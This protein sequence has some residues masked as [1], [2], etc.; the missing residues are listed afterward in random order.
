MVTAFGSVVASAL[1]ADWW[2]NHRAGRLKFAGGR[3]SE[4][5][6]GGGDFERPPRG[7]QEGFS[8]PSGRHMAL[9]FFI[10]LLDALKCALSILP[11][12]FERVRRSDS[13]KRRHGVDCHRSHL[14][15]GACGGRAD[16]RGGVRYGCDQR[17]DSRFCQLPQAPQKQHLIRTTCPMNRACL[18]L[19]AG[20]CF[21]QLSDLSRATKPA[22]QRRVNLPYQS[23]PELALR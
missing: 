23:R 5:G 3:G 22:S 7:S 13:L 18:H 12:T 11:S 16:I 2:C 8:A 14:S 1:G 21:P 10:L 20:Q 15:Q 17:F 6:G 19:S 9:C 4:T